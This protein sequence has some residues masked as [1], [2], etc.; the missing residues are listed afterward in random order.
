ML[1]N[2]KLMALALIL[3]LGASTAVWA[4]TATAPSAPPKIAIV[5]VQE[6]IAGTNDGQKELKALQ[7]RFAPKQTEL[8]ALNDEVEKL[9]KDLD[10]QGSKLSEDERATRVKTLEAKQKTLQRNYED[11]QNEAQQAQQEVLNRL[12]GKMMNVLDTYA[13]ANGYSVVL[14]V[15][16]PQTP[17]LWASETTNITK[18]LVDAYNALSPAAPAAPAAKPS[19]SGAAANKPAGAPAPAKP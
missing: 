8:K 1:R 4:Q 15:S 7:A 17:V 2:Q 12:G 11:Y 19:G 10:T 9:K 18:Q 16:N 6:A 5:Q 13:K 14:D 3:G